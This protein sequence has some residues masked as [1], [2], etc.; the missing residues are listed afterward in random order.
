MQPLMTIGESSVW[1]SSRSSCSSS[2][3]L[4]LNS[5]SLSESY[6]RR[7]PQSGLARQ[8]A[9]SRMKPTRWSLAMAA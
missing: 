1:N 5:A 2:M 4:A 7:R 8:V 9:L 3:A 6:P